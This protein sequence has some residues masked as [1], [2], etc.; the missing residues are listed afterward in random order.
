MY[1]IECLLQATLCIKYIKLQREVYKLSKIKQEFLV[2]SFLGWILESCYHK[3]VV[4]TFQKPN[5]LHGPV[6]PMYGFGGVL[7]AHSY[8]RNPRRFLYTSAVIPLVVE[9]CSGKWLDCRYQLK[10]WDYNLQNVRFQNLSDSNNYTV[11]NSAYT[12]LSRDPLFYG[13]QKIRLKYSDR[14]RDVP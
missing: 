13:L 8:Q 2:Y 3:R 1:K 7:L 4:G 9:W 10:Y 5:F 12:A 11:L 6:K 14:V